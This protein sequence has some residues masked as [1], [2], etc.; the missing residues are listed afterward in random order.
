MRLR[1]LPD[2][3][4]ASSHNV[5][6]WLVVLLWG[7]LLMG[8]ENAFERRMKL[9]YSPLIYILHIYIVFVI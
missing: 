2:M 9:L 3:G 1:V 7:T 8:Y 6:C 5:Q 4:D